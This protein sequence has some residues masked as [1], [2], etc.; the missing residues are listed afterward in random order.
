MRDC[1]R[2]EEELRSDYIF[3]FFKSFEFI[4][5]QSNRNL[6][7]VNVKGR[8]DH[9][10]NNFFQWNEK[11]PVDEGRGSGRATTTIIVITS[12]HAMFSQLPGPVRGE[13]RETVV[14][15][16]KVYLEMKKEEKAVSSVVCII[17]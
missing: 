13:K 17:S 2:R 14:D 8:C 7:P 4:L 6:L 10:N 1:A 16:L 12:R 5:L 15:L 9:N 3:S 11:K